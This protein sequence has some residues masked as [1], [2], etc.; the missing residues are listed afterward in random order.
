MNERP[1]EG[2]AHAAGELRRRGKRFALVGGLAISVRGEPRAT[3]DVDI[4]VAVASDAELEALVR[5]LAQA[6][7][8]AVATVEQEERRRLGTVRLES[9]A[10]VVVD[11][12]AASCGI[13]AEIVEAATP[14]DI[15]GVGSIPVATAEDLLAMKLLS[16]RAGRARDWDDARGLIEVN[17]ALDL[18]LV[19]RRLAL[20]TSRG[21][22]RKED[23]AAKLEKLLKEIG[24]AP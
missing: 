4:A 9:P 1:E 10:R 3:H 12:L 15:E 13:E 18:D 21:Y 22:A 7:Y 14:I 23:L 17:A 6:G 11:L 16:A 24:T 5:D 2:L 20:I 8:R 19:R